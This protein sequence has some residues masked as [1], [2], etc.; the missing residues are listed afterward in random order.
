MYTEKCGSKEVTQMHEAASSPVNGCLI[1]DR[2]QLLPFSQ[3][4][5]RPL[6][7]LFPVLQFIPG[8]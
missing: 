5:F 1:L 8:G 2:P 7:P 3:F 6:L 4:A